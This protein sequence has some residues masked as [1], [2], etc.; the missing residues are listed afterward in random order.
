MASIGTIMR[1]RTTVSALRW[2]PPLGR[3]VSLMKNLFF[4]VELQE[5]ISE[6]LRSVRTSK[7]QLENHCP[8][9]K[10]TTAQDDGC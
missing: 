3:D 1:G 6:S 4:L 10:S 7:A 8:L 2:M 5:Y 9:G